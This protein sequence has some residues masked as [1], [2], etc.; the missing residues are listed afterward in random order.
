MSIKTNYIVALLILFCT[1]RVYSQTGH[2]VSLG[3]DLGIPTESLGAAKLG[4]GGS[5]QYQLKFSDRIAAQLHIGYSG[6]SNKHDDNQKVS[7][8][9]VRLGAVAF[10]YQDIIFVSADA[11]VSHYHSPSTLTNQTGFSFGAGTGYRY[12]IGNGQF[13]QISGYYNMH[14]FK[15]EDTGQDYNYNW[16]N[17]RAAYGL[18]WGKGKKKEG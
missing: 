7:F 13:I 12:L 18:S 3:T 2:S 1:E 15:R 17:I 11:G 10:I 4:F 9:P 8:L 14:N 16:F 6:F 5:L